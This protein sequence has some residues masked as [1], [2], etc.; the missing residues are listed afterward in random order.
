MS[1]DTLVLLVRIYVVLAIAYN[2]GSVVLEERTGKRAAATDPSFG[3]VFITVLYLVI[4]V[5]EQYDR[6]IYGFVLTVL[7]GFVFYFGVLR[8]VLG[9]DPKVYYSRVTWA[10]AFTINLFGIGVLL[11]LLVSLL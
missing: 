1:E 5:G 10:L 6:V 11:S 3:L 9:Y 7:T 2:V 4:A 8:H